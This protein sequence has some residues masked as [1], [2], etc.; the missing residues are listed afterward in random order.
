MRTDPEAAGSKTDGATRARLA[1][2]WGTTIASV[3]CLGLIGIAMAARFTT[4]DLDDK[5]ALFMGSAVGVSSAAAIEELRAEVPRILRDCGGNGWCEWRT[6]A[7]LA[8]LLNYLAL[9]RSIRAAWWLSDGSSEP[10]CRRIGQAFLRGTL[11]LHL[12]LY[13][14]FL[15]LLWTDRTK[16]HAYSTIALLLLLASMLTILPRGTRPPTTL[17]QLAGVDPWH[18]VASYYPRGALGLV[19][20]MQVACFL[21]GRLGAWAGLTLLSLLVHAVQSMIVNLA[22]LPA[23]ALLFVFEKRRLDLAIVLGVV[24]AVELAGLCFSRV[25]GAGLGLSSPAPGALGSAIGFRALVLAALG[26]SSIALAVVRRSR[27]PP[28]AVYDGALSMVASIGLMLASLDVTTRALSSSPLAHD[29]F[30]RVLANVSPVLWAAPL[31]AA[32]F[33]LR[34]LVARFRGSMVSLSAA[35]VLLAGLTLA[36]VIP[37]AA[38]AIRWWWQLAQFNRRAIPAE[39]CRVEPDPVRVETAGAILPLPEVRFHL[40]VFD[41]LERRSARGD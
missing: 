28:C 12:L 13:L 18:S 26:A 36:V 16:D 38:G 17:G 14:L 3:A 30:E 27:V 8:G 34:W 35:T 5:T 37:V 40:Q 23:A 20:L 7:R 2:R 25:L 15:L 11:G 22:F 33:G 4:G 39:L 10:W 41:W 9:G 6:R 29:V 32:A 19:F 31:L 21:S 24:L 1:E